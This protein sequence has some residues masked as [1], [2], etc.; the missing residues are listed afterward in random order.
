MIKNMKRLLISN[1]AVRRIIQ[2]KVVILFILISPCLFA[3]LISHPS[4]TCKK[5]IENISCLFHY[6]YR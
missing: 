6:E 5:D 1:Y 3:D 2:M 4:L